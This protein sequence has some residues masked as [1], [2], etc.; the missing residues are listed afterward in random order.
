MNTRYFLVS[1]TNYSVFIG[2]VNKMLSNGFE[3]V[4]GV[5][6]CFCDTLNSFKY[7]QALILNK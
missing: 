6:V 5:S 1:E 3:L 7:A 4:G 2:E